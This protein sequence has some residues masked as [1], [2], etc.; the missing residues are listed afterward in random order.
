MSTQEILN[1]FEDFKPIGIEW[2]SD[3]SCNIFWYDTL[4]PL[5][6]LS[7]KSI[8]GPCIPHRRPI[9]NDHPVRSSKRKYSSISTDNEDNSVD[10]D[11]PPGNWREGNF[12]SFDKPESSIKLYL[13]YTTLDDRKIRGAENQS[14]YYRQYGNP[15]YK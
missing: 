6:L 13:R 10:V 4:T 1:Y 12:Q 11:L 3:Q 5:Q 8:P 14:E 2:I 7:T 9:N 15:N